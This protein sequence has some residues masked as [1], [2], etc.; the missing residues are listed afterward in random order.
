M[1]CLFAI[2]LVHIPH[3]TALYCTCICMIIDVFV[4]GTCSAMA[5]IVISVQ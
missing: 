5:T 3:I 1:T 4:R 2:L